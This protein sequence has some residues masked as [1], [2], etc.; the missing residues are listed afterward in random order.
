MNVLLKRNGKLI[1]VFS[2]LFWIK[3]VKK[4]TTNMAKHLIMNKHSTENYVN[5]LSSN[6]LNE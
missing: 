6:R 5:I 3:M 2:F 4:K 1:L